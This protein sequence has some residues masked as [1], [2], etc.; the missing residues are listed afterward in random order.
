ML[1]KNNFNEICDFKRGKALSSRDKWP[2]QWSGEG[3]REGLVSTVEVIKRLET[4]DTEDTRRLILHVSTHRG[5]A[6]NPMEAH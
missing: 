3:R 1:M 6:L 5:S 4:G 2:S